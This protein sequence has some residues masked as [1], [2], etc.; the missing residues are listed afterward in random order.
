MAVMTVV[1]V[2]AVVAVMTMVAVMAVMAV[3]A[4]V[5]VMAMVAVMA[6]MTMVAV[7]AVM[8][9]VAVVAV[10]RLALSHR[11]GGDRGRRLLDQR[12]IFHGPGGGGS[13]EARA[14]ERHR[15]CSQGYDQLHTLHRWLLHDELP[16]GGPGASRCKRYADQGGT[17]GDSAAL[18]IRGDPGIV[19]RRQEGT[20]MARA[21]CRRCT[22]KPGRGVS[23]RNL[24]DQARMD[25]LVDGANAALR[26]KRLRGSPGRATDRRRSL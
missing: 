8:T 6:V 19:G 2:V 18:T 4:V 26:G 14:A 17:C 20:A 13:G 5:A 25:L 21:A 15:A 12:E 22:L 16:T 7:M 11:L 9:M 1:A 10:M 23:A 3:M 24:A